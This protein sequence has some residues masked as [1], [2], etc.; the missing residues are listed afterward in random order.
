MIELMPVKSTF[1]D[2]FQIYEDNGSYLGTKNTYYVLSPSGTLVGWGS[3]DYDRVGGILPW[4]PYFA[5]KV[6]AKDVTAFSC[7]ASVVMYADCDGNLWGWGTNKGLLFAEKTTKKVKIL[8]DVIDVSVGFNHAAAIK[9]DGSLWTWGQNIQGNLGNYSKDEEDGMI[10][11][12][13]QYYPPQ[14]VM[15]NVKQVKIIDGITFAITTDSDLYAWGFGDILGPTLVAHRVADIAYLGEGTLY[16]YL[17]LDGSVSVLNTFSICSPNNNITIADNVSSIFTGGIVKN[18][19]SMWLWGSDSHNST[20]YKYLD[21]V[22]MAVDAEHYVTESGKLKYHSIT[23]TLPAIP[24][25]LNS[26]VPML[27]EFI[28]ALFILYWIMCIVSRCQIRNR[29]SLS[30]NVCQ[31]KELKD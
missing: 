22:S 4:Y 5:R 27:R 3:N 18:D 17:S 28:I 19:N 12:G 7:G 25:S 1:K 26:V 14:K 2:E 6:I 20:Y 21:G 9:S 23:D 10:I 15:E 16:Q 8:D 13:G 29:F 30:G 11:N 24:R 31:Q